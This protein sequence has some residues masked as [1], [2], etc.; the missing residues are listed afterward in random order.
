M[1]PL[2]GSIF[3]IS[4]LSLT[5]CVNQSIGGR[6]INKGQLLFKPY[7]YGTLRDEFREPDV[8]Q[9]LWGRTVS[10]PA[11]QT[12]LSEGLRGEGAANMMNHCYHIVRPGTGYI[13][14]KS[15]NQDWDHVLSVTFISVKGSDNSSV[16]PMT[17]A[18]NNTDA[19]PFLLIFNKLYESPFEFMHFF[20][21]TVNQTHYIFFSNCVF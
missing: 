6:F 14:F 10:V 13:F 15:N 12:E 1:E 11:L 21:V 19:F 9:R 2:K 20:Q 17:N 3:I 8:F 18:S 5:S 4:V 7:I 16:L